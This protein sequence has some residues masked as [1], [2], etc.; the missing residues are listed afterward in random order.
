MFCPKCGANIGD[1]EPFCRF[2]GAKIGASTTAPQQEP[3]KPGRLRRTLLRTA[4]ILLFG[5]IVLAAIYSSYDQSEQSAVAYCCKQEAAAPSVNSQ[6]S[7]PVSPSANSDGSQSS[8]E[9]VPS[10]TMGES[11]SVGYWKYTCNRAFWTPFLGNPLDPYSMQRANAQF[12]V[13]DITAENNDTSSS[14]LPPFQLADVDGR[15]Y[16]QSSDAMMSR[17]F[18]DV[19]ENL[20]PGVSERGMIAFDVPSDRVYVLVLSGG[21]ESGKRATVVMPQSEPPPSEAPS[22]LPP[23]SGSDI[24]QY[25]VPNKVQ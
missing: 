18:F 2:C 23:P 6:Q 19:L 1:P 20:N 21:I 24:M 9:E 4:G 7:A 12:L 17:G 14:T 11:F 13:V 5:L 10:Y 3:R 16:D 8:N 25:P 22:T 15:T